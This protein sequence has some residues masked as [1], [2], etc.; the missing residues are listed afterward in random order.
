MNSCQEKTKTQ[1]LWLCLQNVPS[2]KSFISSNQYSYWHFFA[3]I[4]FSHLGFQHVQP[5]I[6]R[7]FSPHHFPNVSSISVL[8]SSS[9]LRSLHAKP[10]VL[11]ALAKFPYSCDVLYAWHYVKLGKLQHLKS[12]KQKRDQK[13]SNHMTNRGVFARCFSAWEK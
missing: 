1:S 5:L 10:V 12:S 8:C 2:K 4:L 11:R 3:A 13:N 6:R 7:L 9:S